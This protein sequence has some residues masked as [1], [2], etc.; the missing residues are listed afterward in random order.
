MPPP[1]AP[2]HPTLLPVLLPLRGPLQRALVVLLPPPFLLKTYV[3]PGFFASFPLIALLIAFS[4]MASLISP[5]FA[6]ASALRRAAASFVLA[7]LFFRARASAT[8]A[9]GFVA[10]WRTFCLIFSSSSG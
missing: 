5:E 9:M 10:R 3:L 6:T 7:I 8:F 1:L 2:R 4:F